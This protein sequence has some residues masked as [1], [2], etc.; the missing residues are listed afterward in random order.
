MGGDE[1]AEA[2]GGDAE[3]VGEVAGRGAEVAVD[4]VG[5]QVRERRHLP[6]TP[7]NDDPRIAFRA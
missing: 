7:R 3:L 6:R 1:A 5:E 4:V 2:V